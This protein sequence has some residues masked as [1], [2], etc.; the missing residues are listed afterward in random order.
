MIFHRA[1]IKLLHSHPPLYIN[2]STLSKTQH[3]KY[4]GVLLD[5]TV[6]WIQHITY[7][8][9]NITKG[10]GIMYKA[11]RYLSK[12][13][14]VNLY[15]SY[16]YPYSIY[17]IES[18]GNAAHCHLDPIF[19]LQKKIIRIITFSDHNAH[20]GLIYNRLNILP[21]YKLIQNRIRIMMYKNANGMLP[22]VMNEL[23]TV[24]SNIHEHTQDKGLCYTLI[25]D[26]LIF[27]LDHLIMLV[28]VYG[29]LYKTIRNIYKTTNLS[30]CSQSSGY[31]YTVI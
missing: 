25:G 7:V 17:G 30:L 3:F 6:S 16:I 4:L 1:R 23:F 11:R 2:N 12:K 15:H 8:K 9:N 22:P 28:H 21:L 10:M 13:S 26:I 5:H 18:W 29:M 20:T 27:S 14:L 24:N 31:Y 19:K